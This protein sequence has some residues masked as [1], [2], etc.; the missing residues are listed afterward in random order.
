MKRAAMKSNGNGNSSNDSVEETARLRKQFPN[1][2]TRVAH[3]LREYPQY[4]T[5]YNLVFVMYKIIFENAELKIEV[6][7]SE[8]KG[9]FENML[10]L[11]TTGASY[12]A[13]ER[14]RRRAIEL[15][16]RLVHSRG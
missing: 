4:A 16:P 6:N 14:C 8:G 15:N 12:T 1:I 13:V 3:I 10:D 9:F 5:D 11:M 7:K 2:R